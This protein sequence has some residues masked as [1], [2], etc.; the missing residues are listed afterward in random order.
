MAKLLVLNADLNI[1]QQLHKKSMT[2]TWFY[3][4]DSLVMSE[5]CV[6][7]KESFFTVMTFGERFLGVSDMMKTLWSLKAFKY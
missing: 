5:S 3:L 4:F 7:L 2:P 6:V 1:Q